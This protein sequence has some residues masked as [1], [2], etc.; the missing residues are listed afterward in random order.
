MKNIRFAQKLLVDSEFA[1]KIY[2]YMS[3]K[4]AGDDFDPYENNYTFS[5]LNPI[6]IKAYVREITP[7]ALVY[8]QFGLDQIG[9]LEIITEAKYKTIFEN[10]NKIV[11]NG[12]NYIVFKEGTG[13]SVITK[14]PGNLLHVV[15]TRKG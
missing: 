7:E 6:V 9:A 13:K 11:V 10:C 15:I 3:S 2:I 4:V 5:N 14:R 8:R 1:T 12:D